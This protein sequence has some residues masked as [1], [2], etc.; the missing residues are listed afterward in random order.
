VDDPDR[1]SF[2]PLV[3]NSPNKWRDA[4]EEGSP[5]TCSEPSSSSLIAG[6]L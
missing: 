5:H 3:F 4:H 1:H 6:V 2:L